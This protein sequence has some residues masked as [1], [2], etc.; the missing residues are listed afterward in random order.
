MKKTAEEIATE[1]KLK[2]II[3]INDEREA[4]QKLIDEMV[5]L[6]NVPL[7]HYQVHGAGVLRLSF[8]L[9]YPLNKE[10][11]EKILAWY[12]ARQQQLFK[13]AADLMK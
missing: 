9:P 7:S 5:I 12:Q 4:N 11:H 2:E 13:Q 1:K 3:L 10:V 8:A 6:N